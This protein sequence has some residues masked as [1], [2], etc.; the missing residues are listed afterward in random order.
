MDL[1]ACHLN[2]CPLDLPKLMNARDSDFG[3]D[4]LGIRRYINRTT[5]QL[6]EQFVLR[7][8]LPEGG[9]K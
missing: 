6:E 9:G 8:A 1:T 7:C 3:H 2:G 4:V 5:G